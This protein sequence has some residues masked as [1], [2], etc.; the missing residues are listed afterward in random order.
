[1]TNEELLKERAELL[2]DRVVMKRRRK[3]RK[4]RQP[5]AIGCWHIMGFYPPGHPCFYGDYENFD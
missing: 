4:N 3:G 2:P 1:M 5:R